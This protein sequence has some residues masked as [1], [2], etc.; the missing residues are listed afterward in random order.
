MYGGKAKRLGVVLKARGQ[1]EIPDQCA[2]AL[3]LRAHLLGQPALGIGKRSLALKCLGAAQD[4]GEWRA[5]VVGD[6]GDPVRARGVAA[7][8]FRLLRGD[9]RSGAVELPGEIGGRAPLRQTDVPAPG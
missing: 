3:G 9:Q 8:D 5:D 6:A 7:G 4:H 1:V 2:D